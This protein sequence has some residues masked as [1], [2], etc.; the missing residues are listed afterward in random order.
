MAKTLCS[1][2]RDPRFVGVVR[3]HV[4]ELSPCP[5]TTEPSGSR[6]TSDAPERRPSAARREESEGKSELLG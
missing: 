3:S 2:R 6:A 4:L 1:Q 5:T